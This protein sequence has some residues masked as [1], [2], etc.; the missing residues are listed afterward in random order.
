MTLTRTAALLGALIGAAFSSSSAIAAD[1]QVE[2]LLSNM[3]DGY[4]RLKGVT[5]TTE[6]QFGKQ[7]FVN[8]FTFE[9]PTKARISVTSPSLK[10]AGVLLTKICDG[11]TVNSKRMNQPSYQEKPYSPDVLA[12]LVPVNLESICF[13]DWDRQLSTAP[14]KNMEHSTF[15]I[16]R[17]EEWNGRKWTVLQETASRQK[18]VCSYYIDPAT[19]IIWRTVVKAMPGGNPASECDCKITKLNLAAK[20]DESEFR[21][22]RV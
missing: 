19:Y 13:F 21:M 3:R 6:S 22:V 7:V 14:G 18:V 2:A 8:S 1:P 10:S 20:V 17:N 15:K 12:D 16:A 11:K 4:K 5:Y 9:S